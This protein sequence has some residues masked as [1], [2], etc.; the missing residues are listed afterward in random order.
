[1]RPED[2]NNRGLSHYQQGQYE[3]EQNHKLTLIEVGFYQ[4][5]IED[6]N[7]A[8]KIDPEHAD[9]YHNRGLAY[10]GLGQYESAIYDFTVALQIN[11]DYA[12]TYNHRGKIQHHA[13][14]RGS[15]KLKEAF[16]LAIS[17]FNKAI[18]IDPHY[19]EAYL[20]RA[21]CY[22]EQKNM[23]SALKDFDQTI[24]INSDCAEAYFYRGCIFAKQGEYEKAI[25]DF[26]EAIRIKPFDAIYHQHR[27]SVYKEQ[28]KCEL[29]I[30]DLS[31]VDGAKNRAFIVKKIKEKDK[32]A[33]TKSLLANA[34]ISNCLVRKYH[35]YLEPAAALRLGG[36]GVHTWFSGQVGNWLSEG[37][38]A[39]FTQSWRQLA[40]GEDLDGNEVDGLPNIPSEVW[41]HVT[42]YLVELNERNSRQ[43][44]E[45]TSRQLGEKSLKSKHPNSAVKLLKTAKSFMF[46]KPDGAEE[47]CDGAMRTTIS[48]YYKRITF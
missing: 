3:H 27:Y 39:W 32:E 12:S 26:N 25:Q 17:D 45:A 28:G 24:S 14:V 35:L 31:Y 29:A 5:A 23:E 41:Q 46:F 13:E 9:A 33:D 47:N 15:V 22:R 7:H 11:P 43:V 42:T 21:C 38:R 30:D 37:L 34:R 8:L 2:L 18:E 4:L 20:N 48:R 1:M 36:P 10:C 16:A 40:T 19:A 44:R 6:F